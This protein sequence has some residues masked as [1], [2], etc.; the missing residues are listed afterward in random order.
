MPGGQWD[1]GGNA[2][3]GQWD[4]GVGQCRG[5]AMV[6][7]GRALER[8]RGRARLV[9]CR[10]R[11]D[12]GVGHERCWFGTRTWNTCPRLGFRLWSQGPWNGGAGVPGGV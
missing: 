5:R 10:G 11:H 1:A 6:C 3:V 4:A 2:G 7:R 12:A 8:C 9:I